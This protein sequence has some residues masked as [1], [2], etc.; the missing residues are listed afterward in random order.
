MSSPS[1]PRRRMTGIGRVLVVVYAVVATAIASAAL[2]QSPWWVHLAYFVL[3]GI[4]WVLPAM[5]IIKWMA[6]PKKHLFLRKL[7]KHTFYNICNHIRLRLDIGFFSF[8]LCSSMPYNFI[9][10]G[11]YHIDNHGSLT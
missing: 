3:T 10:P 1:R 8:S 2:A 6:G 5:L 11:V 4:L 7:F 9:F